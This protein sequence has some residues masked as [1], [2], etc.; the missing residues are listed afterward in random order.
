[1][2]KAVNRERNHTSKGHITAEPVSVIES[3]LVSIPQEHLVQPPIYLKWEWRPAL[4][5]P[6][7]GPG[8]QAQ[9]TDGRLAKIYHDKL[10]LILGS[11][12]LVHFS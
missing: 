8:C 6:A 2:A 9:W 4:T 3:L 11:L 10:M 5:A 12:L 7:W 1:M